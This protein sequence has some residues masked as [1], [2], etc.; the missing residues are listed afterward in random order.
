MTAG[1][2]IGYLGHTGYSA[3]ENVNNIDVPHLHWGME[4]VFDETRRADG[5]E[6]WVD[7]YPLTRFLAKHTQEVRKVPDTKEWVRSTDMTDPAVDEYI[8][9]NNGAE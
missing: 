6:I 1:D 4:L 8:R 9:G 7:V 5:Y 3:T 2:V